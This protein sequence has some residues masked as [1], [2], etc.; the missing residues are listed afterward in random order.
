MNE[1]FI[2]MPVQKG[3]RI[4]IE[5]EAYLD[6][7][8]VFDS[9]ENH[10]F[11]MKLTVGEGKFLDAFED[12]LYGMEVG[13]V[14]LIRLSPQDAY[15]EYGFEKIEL[16]PREKLP[17]KNELEI[18]SL[19]ILTDPTGNE[20]PTKVLDF[21]DTEVTLDFNHPLAGIT[22]NYRVTVIEIL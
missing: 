22:L 16:I 2:I 14:K 17:T 1:G 18:G 8:Q 3:D 20:I 19:L 4:R 21:T 7:G 13:E 11:P 12:A 10:G 15:G 5:Y 9:T 6:D